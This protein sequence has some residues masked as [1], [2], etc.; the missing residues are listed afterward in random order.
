MYWK[1]LYQADSSQRTIYEANNDKMTKKMTLSIEEKE[2]QKNMDAYVHAN[3]EK[4]GRTKADTLMHFMKVAQDQ[5]ESFKKTKQ[6]TIRI[7]EQ[8]LTA[9]KAK[10]IKLWI[11]YQ[12]LIGSQL[13]LFATQE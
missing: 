1:Q 4:L 5:Y 6:I 12:T 11:P 10:S 13:H 8:D 7:S 2:I 9:I 3:K